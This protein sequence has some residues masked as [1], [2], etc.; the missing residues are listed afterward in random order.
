ME[1]EDYYSVRLNLVV[2]P[3]VFDLARRFQTSLCCQWVVP[4]R[5]MAAA[6]A[7]PQ[8]YDALKAQ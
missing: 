7:Q 4:Q 1:M 3:I 5:R 2:V 6:T 8:P